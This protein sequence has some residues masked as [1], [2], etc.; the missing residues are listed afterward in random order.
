MEAMDESISV[1]VRGNPAWCE[2][3]IDAFFEHLGVD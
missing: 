2:Q 1:E 3:A